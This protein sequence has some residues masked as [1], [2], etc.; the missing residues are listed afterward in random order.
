VP[1]AIQVAQRL[2]AGA[3]EQT[4]DFGPVLGLLHTLLESGGHLIDY[5]S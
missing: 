5:P 4:R 2:R 3:E 1:D